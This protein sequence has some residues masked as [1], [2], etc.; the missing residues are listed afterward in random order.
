M[1]AIIKI[2]E[3]TIA[4]NYKTGKIIIKREIEISE[5]KEDS[6]H[7]QILDEEGHIILEKYI[8]FNREV[9]IYKE[10]L[11][12]KEAEWRKEMERRYTPKC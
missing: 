3:E 10:E 4:K 11:A 6:I 1:K 2:E 9:K 7:I 8:N 5:K 12:K